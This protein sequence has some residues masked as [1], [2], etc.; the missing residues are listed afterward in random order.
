M[1][2]SVNKDNIGQ[3]GKDSLENKIEEAM[4]N[5]SSVCN[6]ESTN[7]RAFYLRAKCHY[8]FGDF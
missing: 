1:I 4:S 8:I 7:S 3:K 2:S 6:K 5:L